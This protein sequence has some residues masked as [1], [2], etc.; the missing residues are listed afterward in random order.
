MVEKS[1]ARK[2]TLIKLVRPFK[3][4]KYLVFSVSRCQDTIETNKKWESLIPLPFAFYFGQERILWR[5]DLF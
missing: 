1:I 4:Y 2:K 3:Y 5:R